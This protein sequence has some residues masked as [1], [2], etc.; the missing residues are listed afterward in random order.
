MRNAAHGDSRIRLG[1]GLQERLG[2]ARLASIGTTLIGTVMLK[3]S[4]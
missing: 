2:L 1:R 3:M 4:K